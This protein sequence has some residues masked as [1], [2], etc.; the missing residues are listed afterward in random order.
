MFS[1]LSSFLEALNLAGT[2]YFNNPPLYILLDDKILD[3]KFRIKNPN[4]SLDELVSFLLLDSMLAEAGT[5]IKKVFIEA[6][7]GK[8]NQ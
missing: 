3:I 1:M 5:D 8:R 4:M 2:F 7:Y 6:T